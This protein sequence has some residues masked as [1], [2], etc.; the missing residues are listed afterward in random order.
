M[1]I[2]I[3]KIIIDVEEKLK[4]AKA[5]LREIVEE[6]DEEVIEEDVIIEVVVE[7]KN[8]MR[9]LAIGNEDILSTII[10]TWMWKK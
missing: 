2:V 4:K 6:I 9:G 10:Y 5:D 8:R 7:D 3:V 1:T